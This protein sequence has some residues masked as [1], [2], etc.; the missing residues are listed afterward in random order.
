[1]YF[2]ETIQND[3]DHHHENLLNKAREPSKRLATFQLPHPSRDSIHRVWE[4]VSETLTCEV[5]TVTAVGAGTV[6]TVV[7]AGSGVIV[8]ATG[9]CTGAH[10]PNP[11]TVG[12]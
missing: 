8:T 6:A 2:A 9:A 10:L 1:M 5:V 7:L 4:G 3:A 12:R 11:G